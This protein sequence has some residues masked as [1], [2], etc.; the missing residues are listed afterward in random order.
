MDS[1]LSI[2]GAWQSFKIFFFMG[3][4]MEDIYASFVQLSQL[5]KII[6]T[7][8]VHKVLALKGNLPEILLS[9]TLFFLSTLILMS[10]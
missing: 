1:M 8:L 5:K 4:S 6:G 10:K 9:Y 2:S 7:I 3:A